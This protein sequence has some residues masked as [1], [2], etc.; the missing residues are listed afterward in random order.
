[1]MLFHRRSAG[2]R[3]TRAV[4]FRIPHRERFAR[5]NRGGF[6]IIRMPLPANS[7]KTLVSL[8]SRSRI[9]NLKWSGAFAKVHEQVAGLLG[10]PRPGVVGGDA[11]D[12]HLP[13]PDLHH[14]QDMQAPEEH[15]VAARGRRPGSRPPGR[16]GTASR[17]LTA[18][19][20]RGRE[21]GSGQ[22]PRIVPCRCGTRGRGVHP[23]CGGAPTAGSAWPAAGPAHGSPPGPASARWDSDR[24]TFLDHAPVPGKQGAGR[25]DPVQLQVPGQQPRQCGDHRTVS[26]VRSRAG[27][28][29][30]A[31]PRPHAAAPR[32]RCPSMCRCVSRR[33]ARTT[34]P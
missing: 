7:S 19:R 9:R 29:D 31:A 8:L 22:D 11:Q 23:G 6:L 21:P 14:Q 26:P 16:T 20:G 33:P 3:G 30:G 5:G 2:S 10:G 15:G 34:G 18:R 1:M 13:G 4:A 28:P 12:V 25:H 32:S 24:S 17:S 27:K